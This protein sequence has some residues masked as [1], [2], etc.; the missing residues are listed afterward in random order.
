MECGDPQARMPQ[1]HETETHRCLVA[2]IDDQGACNMDPNSLAGTDAIMAELRVRFRAIN[3]HFDTLAKCLDTL[4]GRTDCHKN[5][6]DAA[7]GRVSDL[8]D[9]S[10]QSLKRM[11]PMEK[12]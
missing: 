6:L 12:L 2:S 11:E 4:E 8:E 9:G 3:G 5:H 1:L 10:V 7:E